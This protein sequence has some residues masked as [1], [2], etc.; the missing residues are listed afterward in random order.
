MSY[1]LPKMMYKQFQDSQNDKKNSANKATSVFHIYKPDL[2]DVL[3]SDFLTKKLLFE[4]IFMNNNL[5]LKIEADWQSYEGCYITAEYKNDKDSIIHSLKMF[6]EFSTKIDKL[7][8]IRRIEF[9]SSDPN[10]Q[11]T[12][13]ITDLMHAIKW[14]SN[15]FPKKMKHLK[16][17]EKFSNE[18]KDASKSTASKK[19]IKEVKLAF[20][21]LPVLSELC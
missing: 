2:I 4:I 6:V 18:I 11:D 17:A 19:Y 8:T 15:A 20:A 21:A 1:K 3:I 14:I 12:E 9:Y 5:S 10:Y 16:A 7:H 13:H